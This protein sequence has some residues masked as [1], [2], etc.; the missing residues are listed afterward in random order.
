MLDERIANT[1]GFAVEGQYKLFYNICLYSTRARTLDNTDEQLT[2]SQWTQ[3]SDWYPSW[4]IDGSVLSQKEI[5]ANQ[6]IQRA[7]SRQD[8][9][10]VWQRR[11]EIPAENGRTTTK[12]FK[13]LID[14]KLGDRVSLLSRSRRTY[15][16]EITNSK[17]THIDTTDSNVFDENDPPYVWTDEK[18]PAFT[19]PR[20]IGAH[21]V[22]EKL[23]QGEYRDANYIARTYPN[24]KYGFRVSAIYTQ[25]AQLI[26]DIDI[27]WTATGTATETIGYTDRSIATWSTHG[28]GLIRDVGP[29]NP[30]YS[31][32]DPI[33][34]GIDTFS[35]SNYYE[36]HANH[37]FADPGL[38]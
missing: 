22:R 25:D 10:V 23:V 20:E 36:Y 17:V 21:V 34:R 6:F 32:G 8:P 33:A 18:S 12:T 38:S 26:E 11:L 16:L 28:L 29:L 19:V 27:N 24:K 37:Q 3:Y 30:P 5:E 9:T 14:D 1:S 2:S 4:V 31:L 35:G 13:Q 7:K 15:R